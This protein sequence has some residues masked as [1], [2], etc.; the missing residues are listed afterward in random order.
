MHNPLYTNLKNLLE[1][2]SFFYI[3]SLHIYSLDTKVKFFLNIGRKTKQA[4]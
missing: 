3:S 4:E 2:K 1:K